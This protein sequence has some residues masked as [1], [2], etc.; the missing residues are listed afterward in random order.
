MADTAEERRDFEAMMKRLGVETP[1]GGWSQ[2][3]MVNKPRRAQ[4]VPPKKVPLWKQREDKYNAMSTEAL[5]K[6]LKDIANSPIKI[7]TEL[8][9]IT[10]NKILEE[11]QKNVTTKPVSKRKKGGI[12]RSTSADQDAAEKYLKRNDGGIALKTRTF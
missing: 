8:R 5:K 12:V 1:K 9:P 6:E 10:I 4:K 7:R 2:K 3:P 11:R